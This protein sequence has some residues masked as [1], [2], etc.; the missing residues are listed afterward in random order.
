MRSR[1][2]TASAPDSP[3]SA[4]SGEQ[5]EA[6]DIE[7]A[8]GS[9]RKQENGDTGG[10]S[11]KLSPDT[12]IDDVGERLE[13]ARKD[14]RRKIAESLANVTEAALIEKPFRKVYKK[15]D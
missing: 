10:K 1:C 9:K 4:A 6:N 3:E 11:K 8:R 12:K 5:G 2:V 14:M 15:P 7:E 13:G